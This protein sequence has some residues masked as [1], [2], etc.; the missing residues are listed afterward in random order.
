MKK[1]VVSALLVL[2]TLLAGATTPG[3][4]Q[5]EKPKATASTKDAKGASDTK[6][7]SRKKDAPMSV[8]APNQGKLRGARKLRV[9]DDVITKKSSST[10]GLPELTNLIQR[11]ARK[12]RKKHGGPALLVGD[13]SAKLGGPLVGHNSHQSGRDADI[14]FFVTNSKG[15]PFRAKRFLP[16]DDAGV[17]KDVPWARFD[18]ARNWAL[19]RALLTDEQVTVRHIFVT[20]GL[21]ARLLAY[22]KQKKEPEE[23]I[24]RAATVL[25][26][27]RDADVHDDHFHI[28]ISCPEA[29]RGTCIE[30]SL[31][32]G[33]AEPK[34]D[35][36]AADTAAPA[37]EAPAEGVAALAEKAAA[38][39]IA[40]PATKADKPAKKVDDSP[41]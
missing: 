33:A 26:A 27:P 18:D 4:A 32:K 31:P 21:E 25:M 8:G 6:R 41:Y 23:L 28:R 16:F 29:M 24:T 39:A 35:G 12:V 37:K 1:H 19:V 22:A 5:A 14:G 17:G 34:A 2:A 9:T 30:D 20:A 11:A 3:T 7:G 40:A 10:W 38:E 13:L 36:D 15:K